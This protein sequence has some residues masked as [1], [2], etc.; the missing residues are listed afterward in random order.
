M[1]A[2]GLLLAGTLICLNNAIWDDAWSLI[3][4][5]RF[6]AGICFG[7][8]YI[9]TIIQISDNI[10]K[11]IRGYISS[12]LAIMPLFAHLI[13]IFKPNIDT[14]DDRGNGTIQ[15]NAM[16]NILMMTLI[17]LTIFNTFKPTFRPLVYSLTSANIH[18]ARSTL[19]E[20]WK[21]LIDPKIIDDE[22]NDK[23]KMC[24][25]DC[26]ESLHFTE[27][28]KNGNWKPI[29]SMVLLKLLAV[30]T[31]NLFLFRL[32]AMFGDVFKETAIVFFITMMRFLAILPARYGLDKLGRKWFLLFS[33]LSTGCISLLFIIFAQ[34]KSNYH[35]DN[36]I[37]LTFVLIHM[38]GAC[39]IE[40]VMH[41]YTTEA[42]PLSKRNASIAFITCFGYI[43]EGSIMFL[44]SINEP[45]VNGILLYS[46]PFVLIAVTSLTYVLLPE[47][48][49]MS[50]RYCRTKFN[51]YYK[52]P[53]D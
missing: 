31:S 1:L 18:A 5:A 6:I 24:S 47:T 29:R 42:F 17:I 26:D 36:L 20:L 35:Y 53:T 16:P 7:F 13:T 2:F 27:V 49:G 43:C 52:T 51:E 28:F 37:F 8:A 11:D 9:T 40:P 22:I 33:G 10:W 14:D 46:M 15:H 34:F 4:I 39:G 12:T 44:W 32:S 23:V 30:Y 3:A 25:E 38:F 48:M 50:V 45:M 21:N 19:I 41:T